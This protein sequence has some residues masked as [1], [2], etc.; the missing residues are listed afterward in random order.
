MVHDFMRVFASFFFLQKNVIDVPIVC[1]PHQKPDK[2]G[3]CRDVWYSQ[4]SF[5]IFFNKI[6]DLTSSQ[7]ENEARITH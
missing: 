1:P 7:Y 6:D 5:G 3:K 4:D 2:N